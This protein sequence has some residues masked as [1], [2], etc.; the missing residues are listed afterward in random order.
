MQIR[1]ANTRARARWMINAKCAY[2]RVHLQE[3]ERGRLRQLVAD[4]RKRDDKPPPRSGSL[5]PTLNE[6]QLHVVLLCVC[7]CVWCAVVQPE[8][9]NGGFGPRGGVPCYTICASASTCIILVGTWCIETNNNK[10]KRVQCA[11][12]R[13]PT[14]PKAGDRRAACISDM[15]VSSFP[16]GDESRLNAMVTNWVA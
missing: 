13:A 12:Q 14:T 10:K 11:R 5:H 2:S 6:T 4:E 15:G 3:R 16:F 8:N 7:T 1:R 9:R